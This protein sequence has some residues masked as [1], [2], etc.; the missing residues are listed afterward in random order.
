M[1]LDEPVGPVGRHPWHA[2]HPVVLDTSAAVPLGYVPAGDYA[3]TVAAEVDWL[4]RAASGSA[5][6]AGSAM[7]ASLDGDYFRPMLDYTAE[8]RF[9][10][11]SAFG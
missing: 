4:V 7:L 10:A 3:V 1:L 8:D 9:Y 2:P 6:S 5:D 11:R